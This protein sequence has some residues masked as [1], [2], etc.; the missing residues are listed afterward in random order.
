[1]PPESVEIVA[2]D[3]ERVERRRVERGKRLRVGAVCGEFE[4]HRK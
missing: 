2:L 1:M 4:R 3:A